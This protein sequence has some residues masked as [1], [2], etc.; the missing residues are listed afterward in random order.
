MSAAPAAAPPRKR[1]G[2]HF[3]TDSAVLDRLLAAIAPAPCDW[4]LEIGPGKGAL[5]NRLL[6][7]GAQVCAVE[8]D[9]DLAAQLQSAHANNPRLRVVAA[10]I[11][12][13]DWRELL[14][15][16]GGRA[17]VVGNLPYNIST[18]LL[19]RLAASAAHWQSAHIMLQQEVA[20]R[21][22]APPGGANYGRLGARA[23]FAFAAK[24]LFVV[25]PRAFAPPPK[26]QSAVVCLAPRKPPQLVSEALESVLR[27][28]FAARRKTLQNALANH[29]INWQAANIDPRR[30]PQTLSPQEFAALAAHICPP[31]N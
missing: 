26:V 22:A 19:L 17:R 31:K 14:A 10:N 7:A 30:R 16:Q 9:R 27:D 6:A 2:Q 13:C 18:P 11:L 3:L 5:T 20:A 28:A 23:A 12:R 24:K 8:I 29:N 21:L 25:S 1:F 15:G 4:F